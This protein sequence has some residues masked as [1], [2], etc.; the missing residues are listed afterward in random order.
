V[1]IQGAGL[2]TLDLS[3]SGEGGTVRLVHQ[4]QLDNSQ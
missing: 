2:V 4:V 1:A 3:V